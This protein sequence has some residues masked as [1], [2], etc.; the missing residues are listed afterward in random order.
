[1]D[2]QE[3]YYI[4]KNVQ[5]NLVKYVL[6]R[7]SVTLKPKSGTGWLTFNI[8]FTAENNHPPQYRVTLQ[9]CPTVN[10]TSDFSHFSFHHSKT[11][12]DQ[13]WEW[14]EYENKI[15]ELAKSYSEK[16]TAIYSEDA[17][18]IFWEM[19]LSHYDSWFANFMPL[20]LLESLALT[21]E[22]K[23]SDKMEAIAKVE[24][25]ISEKYERVFNC[26][27][28]IRQNIDDKTYANWLANIINGK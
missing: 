19:F 24:T 4:R 14:D 6:D 11:I 1:M 21:L 20:R 26:W 2:L 15:R 27:K 18:F 5:A 23:S 8:L 3:E 22:G 25:W 10:A 28:T 12:F 17:T 7:A 16:Y 9:S 13:V